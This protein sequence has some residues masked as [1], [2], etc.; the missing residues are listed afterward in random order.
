MEQLN[1]KKFFT[2]EEN[3]LY[4]RNLFIRF[5]KTTDVY[6]PFLLKIKTLDKLNKL[7]EEKIPEHYYST[8]DD[9]LGFNYPTKDINRLNYLIF[10]T[11]HTLKKHREIAMSMAYEAINKHKIDLNYLNLFIQNGRN[12]CMFKSFVGTIFA[13]EN[14]NSFEKLIQYTPISLMFFYVGGRG[15]TCINDYVDFYTKW[16]YKTSKLIY[17]E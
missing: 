5:L 14:I 11:E 7:L 4:Y 15:C 8:I 9:V 17:N 16:M 1:E 2:N 3:F 12:N 10:L 6:K 13:D